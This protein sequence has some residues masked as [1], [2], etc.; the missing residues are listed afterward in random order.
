MSNLYSVNIASTD[1]KSYYK[2]DGNGWSSIISS[3]P[4]VPNATTIVEFYIENGRNFFIGCGKKNK[5]LLKT[6][7]AGKIPDTVGLY[8]ATGEKEQFDNSVDYAPAF[9]EGD[10][11]TMIIN[12]HEDEE[13][14]S[15]KKNG[16][17]LGIAYSGLGDWEDEVYIIVS[18]HYVH[19]K[20]K[21][22][23]YKVEYWSSSIILSPT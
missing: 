6:Q 10:N 21:L 3:Y 2:V 15:Y 7:F 20:I 12:M 19:H 11:V 8:T 13:Y 18:M 4:I 5:A 16:N 22:T 17:S 9:A 14:V 23:N 1:L